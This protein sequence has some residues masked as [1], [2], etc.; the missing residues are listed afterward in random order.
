LANVRFSHLIYK[1][2]WAR[3]DREG[4]PHPPGKWPT[5]HCGD[6]ACC[7][8]LPPGITP[9]Q[10]IA[11]RQ[12]QIEGWFATREARNAAARNWPPKKKFEEMTHKE[13]LD[14]MY[15]LQLRIGD[16]IWKVQAAQVQREVAGLL[17][18]A[19]TMRTGSSPKE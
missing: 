16:P 13:Q 1:A 3:R 15:Q 10:V 17:E 6:E 19:S 8:D 9:E 7:G 11:K 12:Q 2:A 18:R 5:R 14:A 4:I